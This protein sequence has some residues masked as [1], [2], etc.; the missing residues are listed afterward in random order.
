MLGNIFIFHLYLFYKG[1]INGSQ[2]QLI[3]LW[4]L[5]AM[6]LLAMAIGCVAKKKV[7]RPY[8]KYLSGI[9]SI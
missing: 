3:A 5:N 6:R 4:A 7:N 9:F 8:E 2:T 1:F